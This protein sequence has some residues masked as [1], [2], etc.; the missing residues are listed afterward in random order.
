MGLLCDEISYEFCLFGIMMGEDGKLFKICIGGIVKF[1][2]LLEELIICVVVKFVECELDLSDEECSE[3]VCKVGIGV[4]KYVDFFKYCISDY[5]F[6][7]DIM[8]SFEGVIV[9]YL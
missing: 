6:N 3:I 9:L 2:D 7:W 8:L 1:V 5:I 4:V